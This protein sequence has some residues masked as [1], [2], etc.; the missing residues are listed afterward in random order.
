[1]NLNNKPELLEFEKIIVKEILLEL[2]DYS[3]KIKQY[4][5]SQKNQAL[6][7]FSKLLNLLGILVLA[8]SGKFIGFIPKFELGT[9]RQLVFL[10]AAIGC[11][12]NLIVA[13][14]L[15]IHGIFF[16]MHGTLRMVIEWQKSALIAEGCPELASQILE[17]GISE[18]IERK[19]RKVSKQIDDLY[20]KM[21]KTYENLSERTHVR[22][23]SLN[24]IKMQGEQIA[25][26]VGPACSD[27]MFRRDSIALVTMLVNTINI[28]LRNF[29]QAPVHWLSMFNFM[30]KELEILK[31][32]NL[33]V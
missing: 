30:Q 24:L 18:K 1:V 3:E 4:Y 19:A 15:L 27:E 22:K 28:I 7:L 16:E 21:R 23:A 25:F 17:R 20:R 32:Q 33:N 26:N 29:D 12:R 13:Y 6:D 8:L 31:S 10:S 9:P 2:E 11:L 14:K 5:L